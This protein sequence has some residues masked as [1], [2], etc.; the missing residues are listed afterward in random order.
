MKKYKIKSCFGPTIQGEGSSAGLVVIF[1]RFSGCNRWSG[2]IK[3]KQNSFCSFCDTD[4]LGGE[5]L[6]TDEILIKINFIR[7]ERGPK[8]IV[9]TGG[10]PMLQL[11]EELC[12]ALYNSGYSLYLET[13][14]SI[15]FKDQAYKY[16]KN[17]TV[18]PKQSKEDTKIRVCNDLKLLYPLGDK[19]LN[20]ENFYGF[21]PTIENYYLQPLMDEQYLRNVNLLLDYVYK[22]N[23]WKVSLQLHKILGVE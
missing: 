9:I 13:N 8:N 22:N 21:L 18:S 14:G 7:G 5:L 19:N 23:Q 17:I 16:I 15:D 6:S 2:E 4:F 1:L 20:P 3:H 10:E 11:D 12:S